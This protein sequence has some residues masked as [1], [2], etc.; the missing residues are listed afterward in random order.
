[1]SVS[2]IDWKNSI[3]MNLIVKMIGGMIKKYETNKG[4]QVE[5]EM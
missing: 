2:K 3:K 5:E 4:S 1:M